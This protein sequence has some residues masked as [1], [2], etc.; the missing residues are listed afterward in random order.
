MRYL[1]GIFFL[2]WSVLTARYIQRWIREGEAHLVMS[3]GGEGLVGKANRLDEPV[4]FWFNV[5][6]NYLVVAVT[7]LFGIALLVGFVDF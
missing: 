2:V 6:I 5:A 4:A 7:G 3:V 1:L